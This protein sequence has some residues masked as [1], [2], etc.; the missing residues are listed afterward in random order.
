MRFHSL[1]WPLTCSYEN[2]KWN[3]FLHIELRIVYGFLCITMLKLRTY[4]RNIQI[5]L[6]YLLSSP[7]QASLV[8]LLVKLLMKR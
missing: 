1:F 4:G 3:T 8:K 2:L 6:N 7:F 5:Y